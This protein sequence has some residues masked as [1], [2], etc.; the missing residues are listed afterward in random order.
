MISAYLSTSGFGLFYYIT[1]A[2]IIAYACLA[3]FLLFVLFGGLS[4]YS[5]K[6]VTLFRL[7]IITASLAFFIQ[8]C[9]TG[10]VLSPSLAEFIIPPL[11]A[12]FYRPIRDRYYFM[13][14]ST[15]LILLVGALSYLGHTTDLV[16]EQYQPLNSLL[17]TFFVF[18]IVMIYTFLY[19]G[20]LANKNRLLGESMN[21]LKVTTQKLIH[22]EKMASLGVMSAGVAHEIN[23][24]LNFIKGGI[25]MISKL[26]GEQK[27]VTPFI[28]AVEEGV[29]RASSIV[30]SLGHFSRETSSLDEECDLHDIID[31]CLVMLQHKLKYKVE[32][33][34]KY[35]IANNLKIIGNEGRLH[36][37]IL[38][39]LSNA[40]QA[41]HTRG[42]VTIE[43]RAKR[44]HIKLSIHD[45]GVGIS[46]KDLS[47]ISDPFFTTKPVGE[48]TGLGLA[49]TYQI[50]QQHKGKIHVASEP[51][52]GT[53]FTIHFEF[54]ERFKASNSDEEAFSS[55]D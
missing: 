40:E 34:K 53:E 9:N 12:Y 54:N 33:V 31:N 14:L 13:G 25:D 52:K 4:F 42:K 48:G 28:G 32:V 50:I 8:V 51:S 45:T 39:I 1:G 43:T 29:N 19:R 5:I 20:T 26:V 10:G 7:S 36:Q 23:N 2:Y 38:N 46:Q 49:I 47:K 21:E 16:P 11:L 27:E 24:P 22:S 44:D 6:I 17:A 37:A 15:F 18:I 3:A 35:S 30:N 41:I 55:K